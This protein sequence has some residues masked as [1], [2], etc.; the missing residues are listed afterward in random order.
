MCEKIIKPARREREWKIAKRT[1][2]EKLFRK[3][4][5]NSGRPQL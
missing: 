5:E 3:F 4:G 2:G 1:F